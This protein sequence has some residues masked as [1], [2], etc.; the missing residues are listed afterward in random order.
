MP[1]ADKSTPR[2]WTTESEVT[3]PRNRKWCQATVQA[4][5]NVIAVLSSSGD[6]APRVAA[7]AALIVRAVNRDA[8]FDALVAAL[9]MCREELVQLKL[10]VEDRDVLGHAA[11]DVAMKI[12]QVDAALK[13]A[14]AP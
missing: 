13:L 11:R 5:G 2:P 3:I 8:A 14:E 7:D 6:C 9:K 4:G 12:E 10:Y 1:D